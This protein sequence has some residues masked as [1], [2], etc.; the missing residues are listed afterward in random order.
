MNQDAGTP[1]SKMQA[2]ISQDAGKRSQPPWS[3]H[4]DAGSAQKLDTD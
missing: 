1:F 4:L 2:P 3:T